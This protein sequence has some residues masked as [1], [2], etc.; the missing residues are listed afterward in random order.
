MIR[1]TLHPHFDPE[2]HLFNKSTLFIGSDSSKVDL[3]LVGENIAPIHLKI[4][5]QNDQFILVNEA[6]DPFVSVNGQPFGKKILQSGDLFTIQDIPILFEMVKCPS[7]GE[8]GKKEKGACLPSLQKEDKTCLS[9]FSLP[10]QEE[11]I[12]PLKE[13]EWAEDTMQVY[14]KE[15]EKK[16]KK[17]KEEEEKKPVSLKDDYLKELE[18]E[19]HKSRRGPFGYEA[20]SSHLYQAWK[21]ILIFIFSL[22]TLSAIAG[23]LIYWNAQDKREVQETKAAQG[24]AD[25]TMALMRAQFAHLKPYNQNWS[26]I[27][28]LKNNLQILLPDTFSYASQMDYQGQFNCCPYT[29]RIYTNRDLSHFLLIAQ[30]IP[31]LFYWLIPRSIIVVDSHLMELRTLHDVRGL[32]R[33]LA[34][35]DPLEGFN[36]KEITQLI[37]QG[38]L[39][40]L[41]GLAADSGNCDFAPPK[42]LGWVHPGAE[43]LIYNC[44]RYHRMGQ[45]LIQKALH[46][47]TSKGSSQLVAA[48]KQDVEAFSGLHHFILYSDVGKKTALAIRQSIKTFAPSDQLLFG[49]LLFN[50][51]GQIHQAHLLKEEED[52]ASADKDQPIAPPMPMPMSTIPPKDEL[53][54]LES[55]PFPLPIDIKEEKEEKKKSLLSI[56]T[57]PFIFSCKPFFL[58]GSLLLKTGVRISCI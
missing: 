5:K 3:P 18:D 55:P 37:R 34:N 51:Q 23:G 1:L 52:I 27:D 17:E 40:Q 50:A 56:A 12:S 39:I 16:E 15:L 49:Y 36:G 38:G 22:F 25:L 26:D 43:N 6:N 7:E 28:F 58:N 47:S 35:V 8:L 20:D 2:I 54:A 13:K 48:C 10:F 21:S 42:N 57:I 4:L 14:L 44:P 9:S 29:L 31:T 41:A 53:L 32:N 45:I 24:V 33:L 30:P 11:G 46:L 19:H